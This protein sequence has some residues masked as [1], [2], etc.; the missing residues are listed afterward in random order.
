MTAG[1]D[2]TQETIRAISSP[3]RPRCPHVSPPVRP[4][5]KKGGRCPGPERASPGLT[6]LIKEQKKKRFAEG[7]E[8]FLALAQTAVRTPSYVLD[9][10]LIEENMRV[11]R[12]VKD[13][14]GCKILHALKSY[15][16]FVTFPMMRRYLDGTCAS[17]LNEARL[18]REEFGGEVF[19]FGAAYRKKRSEGC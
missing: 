15:A 5:E 13:R 16:S 19:T 10:T 11:L 18:G 14:T 3:G 4:G 7:S 2:R 8:R 17:G 6:G 12:Y 9:E 1:S